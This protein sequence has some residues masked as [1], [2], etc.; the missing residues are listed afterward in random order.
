MTRE[1]KIT[2]DID[3]VTHEGKS[4]MSITED[5]KTKDMWSF[6]Q[7]LTTFTLRMGRRGNH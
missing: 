7:I 4:R 6:E 5:G 1:I 2:I 3:E